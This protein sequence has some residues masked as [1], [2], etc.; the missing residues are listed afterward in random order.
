MQQEDALLQGTQD[1]QTFT[2][3]LMLFGLST[4]HKTHFPNRNPQDKTLNQR[5]PSP[6]KLKSNRHTTNCPLSITE[7]PKLDGPMRTVESNSKLSSWSLQET[8][9]SGYWYWNNRTKLKDKQQ[10]GRAGDRR[11]KHSVPG[12]A[13]AERWVTLSSKCCEHR[14]VPVG[15]LNYH[16]PLT[17]AAI[18]NPRDTHTHT[19]KKTTTNQPQFHSMQ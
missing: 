12:D 4:F 16:W 15:F 14:S 11:L 7:C 19:H 3:I 2:P 1:V 6:S 17:K 8:D 9:Q 18:K 5:S 13:E 10:Q